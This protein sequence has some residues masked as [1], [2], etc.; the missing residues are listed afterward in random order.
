ME[1]WPKLTVGQQLPQ[2]RTPIAQHMVFIVSFFGILFYVSYLS[3]PIHL[4]IYPIYPIY[5][6]YLS[7]VFYLPILSILSTLCILPI[8][9]TLA[10]DFA[11][12]RRHLASVPTRHLRIQLNFRR[13]FVVLFDAFQLGAVHCSSFCHEYVA[14]AQFESVNKIEC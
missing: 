6:C 14:D 8:L 12:Y 3:D 7:Y 10:F 13:A 2:Q 1:G 5:L 9:Y 11:F 4:S